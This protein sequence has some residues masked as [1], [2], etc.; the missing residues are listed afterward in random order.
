MYRDIKLD[1]RTF[2]E[3]KNDAISRISA[4]CPE[5][6]NH[7]ASDPGIT[8]VELFSYM[9]EMTQ[10]RLNQVPQ[11]NYL[12]FLDLLGIQQRLPIPA[13]SRVQFD[14]SSGYQMDNPAKDTVLIP[15]GTKLAT[16]SDE[17]NEEI[18]FETK[19][20]L[21]TSN[22]ALKNIYSKCYD[23]TREK[24]KIFDY[25]ENIDSKESFFPFSD[26]GKSKNHVELIF[27]SDEFYVLQNDIKMTLIFRLPTTVREFKI[28]EDFLSNMDWEYFDGSSWQR[29][30]IVYDLSVNVDESDA[31]ILSVTFEGNC[32]ALE[33]GFLDE[34]E[35]KESYFIK[36][37]F[38]DIPTWLNKLSV[39]EVSIVANSSI[40]GVL[41]DESYHNYEL[42][43]INNSF[44]P[45]GTRPMLG[46]TTIEEIFYIKCDQAFKEE[47]TNVELELDI[48]SLN[49][50]LIKTHDNLHITYEYAIDDGKWKALSVVD[51]TQNFTESGTLVFSIPEDI[52]EVVVNA[53]EGYWVRAKVISGNYG[54]DENNIVDEKTGEIKNIPATLNA[55]IISSMD[56]KY[57]QKRKDL[58]GCHSL[59]NY[60]YEQIKFD[61]NRPVELFKDEYDNEDA[62]YLAF[63]SYLSEQ[64]L[65]LYFDIENTST[66]QQNQR[67]LEW[68]IL[69]DG[70]W[71]RL[72]I[73]DETDG[74][75]VS[76]DVRI[77]LPKIEKLEHYSLYMQ[78]YERLWIKAKIKF[79]SLKTYPKID[80][81]V[82]N[83]VEVLQKQ[84]H[85][86]EVLG[87]SNGL[88]DMSF[89]LKHQN[90][91]SAPIIKVDEDE[92]K[93]VD[94]FINCDH[95]DKVYKFNGITS[96]IEFGDGKFGK[97]PP[98][99]S[100][101]IV[102]SYESTSGSRGNVSA[103]K[104][105]VLKESINYVDSVKNI[106]VSKGGHDGDSIEDVKRIAPNAL[107]S[108][109]RAVT[110]SDYEN[111]TLNYSTFIKKAKCIEKDGNV[112][113]LVM[114][115]NI[116][117][118]KGFI[119]VSF[120]EKLE[121]YLKELSMVSVSPKVEKVNSV[122]LK[123]KLKL[124]YADETNVPARAALE[125]ELL[126]KAKE[127]LDPFSGLGGNGYE[128]GR[129]LLKSDIVRIINNS[130]TWLVV[131]E[132]AFE[133]DGRLIDDNKVKLSYNEIF[134]IQ[135]IQ[136]E[137]LSYD[138]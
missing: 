50:E 112:L 55:P 90:L 47:G 65:E 31:D 15:K 94:R 38:T 7:N 77:T 59:N 69:I 97:V 18:M 6:T 48:T 103:G 3:I 124:K 16:S 56:I 89:N 23:S 61:K 108:M 35:S 51:N 118:D 130:S 73:E 121:A 21:Y 19:K 1:D 37:N 117:K 125:L 100:K 25:S 123:L 104:I 24:N 60:Q 8:L 128:I 96:K 2:E 114:S 43:D 58:D 17:E 63:D 115:Q 66:H 70:S 95:D 53:S 102:E 99:S 52:A 28:K 22:L 119:N 84:T 137:E 109:K 126:E 75:S 26:T 14:L 113:V 32:E 12:A 13:S 127:Y 110:T 67:V 45:F 133:K 42:V 111:L 72:K 64:V 76:G 92:Y 44:F 29:L 93:V 49:N 81:I 135:D 87:Y 68:E 57:S 106:Y 20:A 79:N 36:A 71:H 27:S 78:S 122:S 46:E 4:H 101:I 11:K 33:K 86:D 54:K 30:K 131:S 129:T 83:S 10:Y 85:V 40:D 88:P 134:D 62:L 138:F 80:D 34:F 9:T 116:L 41:A 91:I 136:I 5:W 98:L 107:N 105:N 132:L 39:Y 74:L 82:L 120:M